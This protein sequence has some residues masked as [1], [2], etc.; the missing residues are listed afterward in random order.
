MLHALLAGITFLVLGSVF[1]FPGILREPAAV[2]LARF[3]EN[4]TTIRWAYDT[5]MLSSLV[6]IPIALILGRTLSARLPEGRG[7]GLMTVATMFGVLARLTQ[8]IG[9][10]RWTILVPFLAD[11]YADPATIPAGREAVAV[12]YEFANR[13]LGMTIGEHLGWVFQGSWVLLLS[14]ALLR[15]LSLPRWLGIVGFVVA[16][17]LLVGTLEQFR[18][19]WEEPLGL[20]NAVGT[21]AFPFWLIALAAALP[22]SRAAI[23]R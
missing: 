17:L 4:R 14:V 6:L 10:I 20:A 18:F 16:A 3:G 21:T 2:V 11:A 23:G 9:F 7:D 22:R 5:F 13:Y 15:R 12:A 19:G 8:I 1:D